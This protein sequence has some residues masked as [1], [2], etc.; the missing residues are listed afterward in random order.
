VENDLGGAAMQEQEQQP[1]YV[2]MRGLL[3]RWGGASKQPI[4]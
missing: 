4:K 3:A 2:I 1:R